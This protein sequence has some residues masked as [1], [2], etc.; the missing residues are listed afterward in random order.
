MGTLVKFRNSLILSLFALLVYSALTPNIHAQLW[1]RLTK[2]QITV[3]LTHPPRLGLNIKRVAFGPAQGR[4]SDEILDRLAE[5]L[6]SSGV[7]VIDRQHLQT[8][9]G[10]QYQSL[11]GYVD[12]Q[13]AM[14]MGKLLGPTALIFVKISRCETQQRRDSSDGH[15]DKGNVSRTYHAYVEMHIRGSLQTVDLATGRIFSA[16]PI[17]EDAAR[18][19]DQRGRDAEYPRDD[20]VR[21]EAIRRTAYDASSMFIP[22][23]ESK[24]L[25]FFN[26]KECN[27]NVAFTML[28]AGDFQGTVRQSE[29][30]IQ[31]CKTWPKLKD[32]SM[33]HAY[34][35]AGLAYLL[36]NEHEKA[37]QYLTEADR[38]KGGDIV[39]E[40]IVEANNSARLEAEMQRVEQRTQ[41][42]EQ[43]SQ[44]EPNPAP[45]YGSPNPEG[46][47]SARPAYG[48]PAPSAASVPPPPP[49]AASGTVED[50]LRKLNDLF[51]KGLITKQDYDTRKAEILKEI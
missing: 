14:R 35:N 50:R 13:S 47:S 4:C 33:A 1:D 36:I 48:A 28:K 7:E 20:E 24:Q 37:L 42:F 26:D 18:H 23:N 32:S 9:L 49:P 45:G 11:S 27:L 43:S 17:V 38:L 10:G 3:N 12:Q 22:W 51:K 39:A 34:Y 44:P 25:Y 46:G 41:E 30:N 6:I 31:A 19:N 29:D 15:D 40:T 5:S 2:P 21:E 16:T 8:A